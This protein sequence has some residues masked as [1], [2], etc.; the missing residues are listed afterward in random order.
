MMDKTAENKIINL[1]QFARKAGKIITGAD[2]CLRELN[3]RGLR[4]LIIAG[5]TSARSVSRIEA[6][7]R[8]N[9]LKVSILRISTQEESSA[10]LGVPFTGIYGITD[11]QFATRMLEYHSGVAKVEEHSANTST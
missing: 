4:L 6:V 7:V 11:K 5:D 1:M 8:E 2:A 10:A 9:E 3:S